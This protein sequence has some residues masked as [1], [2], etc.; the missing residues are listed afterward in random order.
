[1]TRRSLLRNAAIAA[2]AAAGVT[3]VTAVATASASPERR[4]EAAAEET[5][6]AVPFDEVYKGRRIEGRP[7]PE[8]HAHH[9]G[10]AAHGASATGTTRTAGL[11]RTA[12]AS[13]HEQGFPPAP[14][15][16]IKIDGRVLH[17]MRRADG[18]Y[19][20]LLNH[21]E[22]FPTARACAQAAVNNLGPN[23][24]LAL[25]NIHG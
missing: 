5:D 1:M 22:S 2:T 25:G 3:A 19:M 18:T 23:S 6:P 12:A 14:A 7:V 16:E 10:G 11:A 8:G 20:S 4:V 24:Q 15:V 9:G 13:S 21:Y 17:V